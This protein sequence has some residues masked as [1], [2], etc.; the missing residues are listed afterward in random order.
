MKH[1]KR[2][3]NA[4]EKLA[5]LKRT[6]PCTLPD[7]VDTVVQLAS[8][9]FDETVELAA[10]LGVDPRHAE[11]QVRGTCALPHGTG[12]AKRVLVMAK[13]EKLKEAEA[14]GA[15]FVGGEDLVDKI[16]DGWLEFDAVVATPDM[17]SVVG[18][19][20]KVL[21]PKGLMPSPKTG[22][23]TPDVAKAVNEIKAGR[24]E[25]RV[26]RQGNVHV[27]VGK[28]SFG[29]EKL[30]GNVSALLNEIVRAKPS[31]AKGTYL[32]S[33]TLSSTMGPGV[34]VDPNDVLAGAG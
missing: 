2:Y 17:M 7:A 8:A 28:V 31:A 30:L 21:G 1:G 33:V 14:A 12:R 4:I 29:K 10:S 11:Q 19:L 15:D 18:R 34:A 27:P 24:V 22:T 5:S 13:G 25:Y 9:K 6:Q 23:V 3:R 26:D 16:K 20:G 32:K